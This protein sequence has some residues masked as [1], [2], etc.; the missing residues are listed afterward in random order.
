LVA[1]DL[2]PEQ[3]TSA[4]GDARRPYLSVLI[5]ALNEGRTIDRVLDAV[6]A[7]DLGLE[8]VLVDDGSTDDTWQ[9]MQARADGVQVRA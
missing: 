5:A 1:C 6:L 7:V 2:V 3:M 8:V 9:R 4:A